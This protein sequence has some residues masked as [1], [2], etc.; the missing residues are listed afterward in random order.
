MNKFLSKII[1]LTIIMISCSLYSDEVQ[2]T[3]GQ[4]APDFTLVDQNE[5]LIL[6]H[7]IREKR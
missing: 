7:Y 4:I 6:C 1:V 3:E 5:F 2:I